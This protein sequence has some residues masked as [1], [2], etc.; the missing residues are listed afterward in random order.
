MI[1]FVS[2]RD[3]TEPQTAACA[4]LLT[5][6]ITTAIKDASEPYNPDE[7]RTGPAARAMDFLFGP[8][9]IFP[10]Y[11]KLIGSSAEAI[12]AAL[13]RDDSAQRAG[14]SAERRAALQLRHAYRAVSQ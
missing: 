10:L 5:Y 9:S 14:Y 2:T 1:D 4:R 3:G 13:L 11:A 12:R 8:E 7:H 6:I